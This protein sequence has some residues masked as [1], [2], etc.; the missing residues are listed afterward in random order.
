MPICPCCGVKCDRRTIRRHRARERTRNRADEEMIARIDHEDFILGQLR[1]NY[2][3]KEY[4]T[5]Q[6]DLERDECPTS[7]LING[8]SLNIN[9]DHDL[10]GPPELNQDDSM[11]EWIESF[12]IIIAW[13]IVWWT[14][15]NGYSTRSVNC[16]LS[17]LRRTLQ[18][19]SA[20]GFCICLESN[21]IVRVSIESLFPLNLEECDKLLSIRS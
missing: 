7:T 19:M 18:K 10:D 9:D 20:I 16:L 2:S 11:T 21:S 4:E 12:K 6:D 13:I 3:R 17:M 15:R 8:T 14:K 5:F 1:A